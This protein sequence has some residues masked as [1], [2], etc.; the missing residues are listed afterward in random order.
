[1]FSSLV[2]FALISHAEPP[3]TH[4]FEIIINSSEE[5][6]TVI[7]TTNTGVI[8]YRRLSVNNTNQLE[9][10]RTD[11][12]FQKK[13]FGI[14]PIERLYQVAKQ[15]IHNNNLFLVL[16]RPD[17]VYRSFILLK[18][19]LETG[20]YITHYIRNS[21][22]FKPNTFD[23]TSR[24]ALLGGYF[25][26]IPVVMFYNF[27]TLRANILPGL[28]NEAGELTQIH[29]NPDDTYTLLVSSRNSMKQRTVWIKNY[30][31]DGTLLQNT[32]LEPA[33]SVHLLFGSIVKSIE[34][35]QL[36]A[37]VYGNRNTEYSM[38]IFIAQITPEGSHQIRYYNYADI[39]NFFQYLRIKR[40]KKI[41][42]KIERKKIK[43]K[44]LK[45]QYR[46]I[47]HNLVSYKDQY[48]L[49]GEAFYPKYRPQPYYTY[50]FGSD[51]SNSLVFDGYQYTHTAVLGINTNG[52]LLWD[53]SFQI[54]E[55]KT[56]ALD[57]YVKVNTHNESIALLY[58][59]NNKI[60]TKFVVNNT[61]KEG[62]ILSA[63]D[64][65]KDELIIDTNTQLTQLDNWYGNNFLASGT[66]NVISTFQGNRERKKVFF[67]N[68]INSNTLTEPDH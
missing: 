2:L 16:Y 57:Q 55:I 12:C 10:I 50:Q 9:I 25:I 63:K 38:G 30:T 43:G 5:S 36:I 52:Q 26:K 33:E 28:F 19:D 13:W 64:L 22:P 23:V 53:N 4:R 42:A 58:L 65:I 15:A 66:Q 37:G 6:F 1:L 56:F 41:K 40:E 62:R 7:P 24:G 51:G 18:V 45:F 31:S 47:V 49:L 17:F 20:D 46:F 59:F 14:I 29:V 34:N 3:Q 48:I 11:T 54:R 32:I 39:E 68:K 8:L 35:N 21:I 60:Y 44:K 27:E 67:M 61:I